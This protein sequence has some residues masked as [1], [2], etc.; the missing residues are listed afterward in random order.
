MD[1]M[2]QNIQDFTRM[3]DAAKEQYISR[4]LDAKYQAKVLN[5]LMWHGHACL[6][7]NAASR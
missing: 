7:S 2:D 5:S 3:M 4:M 6:W 1:Q